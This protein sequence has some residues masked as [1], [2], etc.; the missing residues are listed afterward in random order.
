MRAIAQYLQRLGYDVVDDDTYNNIQYW[1]KWYQGYV[2]SFHEYRQYNGQK[3]VCRRRKSLGMAKTIAEDWACLALNEKV[4]LTTDNEETTESLWRILDAN[5]F[6]AKGNQLIEQA[7]ALGTGAFVEHAEGDEVK[8]EYIRAGMIYPLAWDNGRITE[9]AFASERRSGKKTKVYL[10]I[11]RLEGGAYVIENK[12]FV[13]EGENLTE[14]ELPEDVM[15]E[16]RTGSPIPRFQ[17]VRPNI[18]NNINPDS[19]MGISV[20]ANAIDQLQ[21]VDLVYDS[22]CNEFRLG[23]KRIMVPV[24]FAQMALQESGDI[25]PIFDDNDTEF[26]CIPEL[27]GAPNKLEEFNMSLRHEAHEAALQTALNTLSLKCGMGKDRYIFNDGGG[28][29]TATEVISEKSDLYQSLKKHELLLEDALR[30]LVLAVC[31]MIGA[32][33]ENVRVDFD[34]SIIEDAS[35]QR[36][37]DR[38]DV[39]DGLLAKWEYRV[40]WFGESEDEA[41]QKAAELAGDEPIGFNI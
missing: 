24:S 13:R 30:G 17:I 33:V 41:R 18:A 4:G 32:P 35:R 20:F 26:Y 39:R 10:N 6:R 5:Q 7:F 29:K 2:R 27:D 40:R 21:A 14:T 1:N 23:K 25:A 34:D 9:C 8:I 3:R 37:V 31:D 16:F 22:Y 11:H 15:P 12:M 28:A 19:P 38:Q 36:E